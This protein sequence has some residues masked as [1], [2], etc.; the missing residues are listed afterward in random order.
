MLFLTPTLLL[1]VGMNVFPLIWSLYL[2]FHRYAADM[3]GRAP[4][5]VGTANYTR[6]LHDPNLW[7]YFQTTAEFVLLA[8]AAQFLIG[9]GVALLLN[10]EFKGKGLVTTLILLPMMLSPAVV[11]LF[12]KLIRPGTL[13]PSLLL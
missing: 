6:L 5:A 7:R 2:S 3:P 11:G 13:F 8:V 9:F 4:E 1:L 12:W 10:R